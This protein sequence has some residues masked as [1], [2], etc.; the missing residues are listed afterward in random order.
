MLLIANPASRRGA[1]GL[2][3]V[4]GAFK[5][6]GVTV[7]VVVTE[8][9]GHAAVIAA[10]LATRYD[11]VF[12]L[13][14]D[15]TAMEVLEIATTLGRPVGVLPG[16]TGNLIARALGTPLRI[17]GA[18][19]ALLAGVDRWI[20]LGSLADGRSFAFAA[21][22][23]FDVAMLERATAGLK[24]RLGVLAYVI[25]GTRAALRV[26]PFVLHAT[27]DGR[28]HTFQA[29]VAFVANFGVALGGLLHLG[30]G[31]APDDGWLDLCVYEPRSAR[32]TLRMGWRVMRRDFE[33][34]ARMHFL[35]GR[36]ITLETDPP[37]LT[38]ADG[39]LLDRAPLA[40]TV[41]PLAARLL[42]P[43]PRRP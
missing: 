26:D 17:R 4:L 22:V 31:I 6:A 18:V 2:P 33:G 40:C 20:D 30:P 32:D 12:T 24:R 35:K 28:R 25:S 29:T 23:G 37:R 13:G 39:E 27:V 9:R 15:G 11:A 19:H 8:R 7:D 41:R 10:D 14:G 43:G 36:A 16:G 38:Q 42:A 21:G 3:R 34:A 5:R 1:R